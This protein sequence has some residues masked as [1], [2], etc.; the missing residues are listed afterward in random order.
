V[1]LVTVG[2]ERYVAD[3]GFGG[4]TLTSPLRFDPGL[5]QITPHEP[6]RIVQEGEAFAMEAFIAGDWQ[7]LYVFDLAPALQADY[8]VS[9]WYLAHHPQSQFVNGIIAARALPGER[10]A[11]RNARYAIHRPGEPTERREIADAGEMRSLLA[12]PF[13]IQLDALPGLDERLARLF[14]AV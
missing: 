3:V 9:N 2:D 10:H 12:G 7:R 6:H 13:G 4:L 11:L 14:A 5:E 1:L 8:E